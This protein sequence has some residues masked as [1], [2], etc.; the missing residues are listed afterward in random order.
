VEPIELIYE[1]ISVI[2]NVKEE[3][4]VNGKTISV[5][6]KKKILK[7][8]TGIFS[9]NTFTAILGPSGCGKTTMLNLISGRQLS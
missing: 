7:E 4:E 5:D 3:Q 9:P 1:K 2:A 6:V 8:C